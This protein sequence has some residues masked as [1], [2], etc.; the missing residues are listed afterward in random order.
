[1]QSQSL[2]TIGVSSRSV[3]DAALLAETLWGDDPGDP[4]T[5]LTAP[6][7]LVSTATAR[8]P[9]TPMFAMLDLPGRQD[10]HPDMI[11]A[12]AELASILGEGAFAAP[13]PNA[14][15]EA[16]A[17]RERIQ[18]AEMSKNYHAYERRGRAEL[19]AEMQRQMDVGRGIAARDY[20]AA[21]DWPQVLRAGL[22]EILERAD[23]LI[24]PA[25]LGPA[26]RGLD[27]TGSPVFNG[28]FTMCGMP[29]VTLPLF[30]D[31]AGMPMGVQ[32]IGRRDDDARL[33]RTAN[34]LMQRIATETGDNA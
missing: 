34:W 9:V 22:N 29:A 26:P 13:L 16:G 21:L 18:L 20:L 5:S 10:M 2:D 19:S 23:A 6:P 25:A 24:T 8:V 11:D 28:L 33:L 7:R 4:A 27:S 1:M 31:T 32:V 15:D 17:I 3:P 14:F 12:M 30:R